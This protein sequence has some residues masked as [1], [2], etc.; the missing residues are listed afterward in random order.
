MFCRNVIVAGATIV[1]N[2]QD[3]LQLTIL[4]THFADNVL[5]YRVRTSFLHGCDGRK[6]KI[7][8]SVDG[9]LAWIYVQLSRFFIAGLLPSSRRSNRHLVKSLYAGLCKLPLLWCCDFF[10]QLS[11]KVGADGH[12]AFDS[13]IHRVVCSTSGFVDV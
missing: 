3:V 11:R 9:F 10:Q 8:T 7:M 6:K 5:N 13:S 1:S 2:I 4:E 12:C